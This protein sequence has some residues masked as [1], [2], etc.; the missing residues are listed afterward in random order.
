MLPH[1]SSIQVLCFKS[2][3]T[4]F[5]RSGLRVT[6]YCISPFTNTIFGF[7]RASQ[8]RT[9]CSSRKKTKAHVRT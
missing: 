8:A 2:R 9:K 6:T 1:S 5:R 3:M 4:S 7:T